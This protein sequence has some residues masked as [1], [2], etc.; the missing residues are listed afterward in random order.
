MPQKIAFLTL[1]LIAI[2]T[3]TA[4]AQDASTSADTP[5]EAGTVKEK[6]L[7]RREAAREG[8]S[9]I[10]SQLEEEA[11]AQRSAFRQ[12]LAQVQDTQKQKALERIDNKL[13]VTNQSIT[14]RFTDILEDLESILDRV[15]A[16]KDD[17]EA[18]GKDV[19]N[20]DEAISSARSEITSAKSSVQ[21]QASKNYIIDIAG[22][23][24]LRQAATSTVTEFKTD[25]SS[26][27]ND[28]SDAKTKV[29]EAAKISNSI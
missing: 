2:T 4:F 23:D 16:Q 9:E 21:A 28:I 14:D 10:Q 1:L 24:T 8:V 3:N 12:R 5:A 6:F 29:V 7:Q 25:I 19:S 27:R 18:E 20:L 26:L 11:D 17:L 15:E 22:D 13:Q